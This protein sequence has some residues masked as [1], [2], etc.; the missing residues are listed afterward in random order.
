[1]LTH[2]LGVL[3]DQFFNVREHQDSCVWPLLHSVF[4]Q[5]SNDVAFTRASWQDQARIAFIFSEP[6]I[7]LVDGSGL[8]VTEHFKPI[9]KMVGYSPP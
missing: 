2:L 1:M 3:L 8:I 5:R 6:L 7:E 4:A 9:S